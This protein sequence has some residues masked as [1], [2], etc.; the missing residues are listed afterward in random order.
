MSAYPDHMEAGENLANV[1]MISN[2][3]DKACEIFAS[4]YKK[5]P[6][7]FTEFEKYGMALYDTK[8]YQAAAEMLEKALNGNEESE[9]TL[10]YSASSFQ[11][12]SGTFLLK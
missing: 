5:Y 3:A 10:I 4:L 9:L 11:N 6:S 7:A 2:Q 12:S 1:Y 8:Q